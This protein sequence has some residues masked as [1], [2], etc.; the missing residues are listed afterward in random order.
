M[1]ELKNLS[2]TESHVLS[3]VGIMMAVN[4]FAR[5]LNWIIIKNHSYIA[6]M[7]EQKCFIYC[8]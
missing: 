1:G 8:A 2:T 3:K 4:V 5:S 7:A 6:K